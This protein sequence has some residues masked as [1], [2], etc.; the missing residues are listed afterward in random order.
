MDAESIRQELSAAADNT[1]LDKIYRRLSKH[2][3]PDLAGGSG[4]DFLVLQQEFEAA[5]RKL[6]APMDSQQTAGHVRT[7]SAYPGETGTFDPLAL[8]ADMGY[9]TPANPRTALYLCLYR[10]H[11]ANLGSH[12]IRSNQSLRKRN[13][14]ILRTLLWWAREYDPLFH[15]MFLHYDQV[16]AEVLKPTAYL[17]AASD[18][19]KFLQEGFDSFMRYQE[20]GRLGMASIARNRLETAIDCIDVYKLSAD[21]LGEFA[22]WLLQEL[23]KPCLMLGS[24]EG[25]RR[26]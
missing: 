5:G 12:K 9:A 22:N 2:T 11:T 10:Y 7:S 23:S 18:A 26:R 3:H 21:G 1:E 8:F 4:E 16:Q 15:D 25:R 17:K 20:D 13:I 19:R 6:Q 24:K 14:L